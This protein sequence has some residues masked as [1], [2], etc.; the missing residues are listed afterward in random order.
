M[1]PSHLAAITPEVTP[2]VTD[3]PPLVLPP[4][5]TRELVLTGTQHKQTASMFA[6]GASNT[7]L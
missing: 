4:S 7:P 6:S 2:E 1:L 5:Q 3:P